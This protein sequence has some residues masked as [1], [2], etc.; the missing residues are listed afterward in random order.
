MATSADGE[1]QRSGI[2]DSTKRLSRT[3]LPDSAGAGGANQPPGSADVAADIAEEDVQT[4]AELLQQLSTQKAELRKVQA[5][6]DAKR[7]ARLRRR[8]ASKNRQGGATSPPPFRRPCAAPQELNGYDR[9]P[10]KY[11]E[12]KLAAMMD[13]PERV[14]LY[15]N[16]M[17]APFHH[18]DSVPRTFDD[19]RVV[20]QVKKKDPNSRIDVLKFLSTPL[21]GLSARAAEQPVKL[22]GLPAWLP[23]NS[24]PRELNPARPLLE[25]AGF[26]ALAASKTV[27]PHSAR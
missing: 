23:G 14:D 9:L 17:Y 4:M 12:P 6:E 26:A 2:D 18:G 7:E 20:D 5:K 22:G 11:L 3:S 27:A 21:E 19:R 25:R 16:R 8:V 10:V 13:R 1:G 24:T 15:K